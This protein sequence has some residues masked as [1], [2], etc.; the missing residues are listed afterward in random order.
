MD[1]VFAN[2]FQQE[3]SE[4][5]FY[6][7]PFGKECKERISNL[8]YSEYD[9]STEETTGASAQSSP[10]LGD[11][12]VMQSNEMLGLGG[13]QMTQLMKDLEFID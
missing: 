2:Y 1:S 5:F 10:I 11:R 12:I 6:N 9:E 3:T 7:E 4:C 8:A 13:E